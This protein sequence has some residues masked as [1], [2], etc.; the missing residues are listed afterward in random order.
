MKKRPALIVP[1]LVLGL[2]LIAIAIVYWAE[3]AHS[4]LSFFPGHDA[5][6]STAQGRRSLRP[7]MPSPREPEASQGL[8]ESDSLTFDVALSS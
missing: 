4:L 5:R 7:K 6:P 8:G 2:A 1:A 3:P